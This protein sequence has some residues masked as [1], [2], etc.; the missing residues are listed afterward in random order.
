MK[1]FLLILSILV[2]FSV[3]SFD[4]STARTQNKVCE[5]STGY[6]KALDPA[7]QAD[8]DEINATRKKSYQDVSATTKQA[9]SVAETMMGE[10][11]INKYG[12]C[13]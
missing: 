1:T 5:L 2:S 6:L 8:V 9:I 3:Y 13:K 12:A 11:L 4:L 7:I 10:K